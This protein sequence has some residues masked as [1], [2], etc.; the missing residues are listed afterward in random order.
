MPT[1]TISAPLDGASIPAGQPVIVA[2]QATDRGGAEPVMVDSVVVQ[3]DDQPA[4]RAGLQHLRNPYETLVAFSVS[5]NVT[6]AE[7]AHTIT[8]VATNDS[9]ITA[10]KS[11][12]V[13]LGPSLA[14][15]APV[16]RLELQTL[17]TVDPSAPAIVGLLSSVQQGLVAMSSVVADAGFVLAGPNLVVGNDA[18]GAPVARI[19]L[20]LERTGIALLPPSPPQF[21]LPRLADATAAAGF[22]QVPPQQLP[23]RTGLTDLPF[24]VAIA[25][26][27]LQTLVDAAMADAA[28]GQINSITVT[29]SAPST[30]TTTIDGSGLDGLIPATVT[31]T[32]QLTAAPVP[33]SNPAV[34][35]PL[36]THSVS[37]SVGDV[38]DWII[39]TVIPII[40]LGLLVGWQDLSRAA[41]A[42]AQGGSVASI[43]AADLPTNVPFH[44]DALPGFSF[45]IDFPVLVADWATFGVDSSGIL[46]TGD[47]TVQA[48][49]QSMVSIA[50][51]GPDFVQVPPGEFNAN[52]VLT[53]V[54]TNLA[55][56]GGVVTWQLWSALDDST[57]TGT[58][59]V[60]NVSQS[61]SLDVDY[62]M[63]LHTSPGDYR[64][65]VTVSAAETCATDATKTLTGTATKEITVRMPASREPLPKQPGRPSPVTP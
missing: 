64:Y 65:V 60:G 57:K 32:E 40:G 51:D 17:E 34:S 49:D 31:I 18:A 25:T 62:P 9:G 48:R 21:P 28:N 41:D 42:A 8:V 26:S 5:V 19:G 29:T 27:A 55:P 33:G 10:T 1:L 23:P 14:I 52:E 56:D 16:V 2:G 7:G 61:A 59:G 63:P 47:A 44:N 46:G 45:D 54:L 50:I 6:G 24:A 36:V 35:G 22:A 58:L 11:V 43:L 12:T 4:V 15:D 30:V 37:T 3:V 38:L 39:G 13:Y 20:W 53:V